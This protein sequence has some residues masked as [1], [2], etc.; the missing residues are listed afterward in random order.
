MSNTMIDGR[1]ADSARRRQRVIKAVND[2]TKSGAEISVSAIARAARVD[3]T[4]IYRHPDLLA[5]VH[6]AQPPHRPSQT[7]VLRS[8]GPRCRPTWPTP[9]PA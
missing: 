3:R 7:A 4:L 5:L 9:T 6:T 8:L 2:A 1:R